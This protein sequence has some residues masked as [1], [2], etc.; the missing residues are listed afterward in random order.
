MRQGIKALHVQESVLI[1]VPEP[2][3]ADIVHHLTGLP[4]EEPDEKLRSAVK[5]NARKLFVG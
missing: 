5:R 4:I 3:Y 2:Y 1:G